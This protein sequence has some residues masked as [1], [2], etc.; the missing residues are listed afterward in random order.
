MDENRRQPT[1]RIESIPINPTRQTP[2][3]S[4]QD[5]TMEKYVTLLA[6]LDQHTADRRV[7][8]ILARARTEYQTDFNGFRTR[9]LTA[10]QERLNDKPIKYNGLAKRINEYKP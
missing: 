6:D 4:A 9:L 7:P 2:P 8:E 1:V 10:L 5:P 3:R